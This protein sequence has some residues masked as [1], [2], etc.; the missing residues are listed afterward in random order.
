[1]FRQ[2]TTA[3]ERDDSLRMC[4]KQNLNVGVGHHT[5]WQNTTTSQTPMPTGSLTLSSH[6]PGNAMLNNSV[7]ARERAEAASARGCCW[8]PRVE[9]V[10]PFE[11]TLRDCNPWAWLSFLIRR[12]AAQ[13]SALARPMMFPNAPRGP[14]CWER[15]LPRSESLCARCYRIHGTLR[16]TFPTEQVS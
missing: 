12:S 3:E 2:A 13:L 15:A 8:P 5:C 10:I 7:F 9:A 1:V 4:L 14:C 6:L 16:K 11:A